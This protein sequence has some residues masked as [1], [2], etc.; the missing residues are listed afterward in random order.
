MWEALRVGS[1]QKHLE[2]VHL[3]VNSCF[4]HWP[5]FPACFSPDRW[6]VADVGAKSRRLVSGQFHHDIIRHR[7]SDSEWSKFRPICFHGKSFSLRSLIHVSCMFFLEFASF[8]SGLDWTNILWR[9]V[10]QMSGCHG[11]WDGSEKGNRTSS[12]DLWGCTWC[13][14]NH[15]IC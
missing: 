11:C 15:S 13:Q 1:G 9:R 5:F 14:L 2:D 8:D 12:H 3:H 7:I 10:A 6:K 4:L